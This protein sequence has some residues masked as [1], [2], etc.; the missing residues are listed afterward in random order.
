MNI[1]DFETSEGYID[2]LDKLSQEELVFEYRKN[3]YLFGQAKFLFNITK[4]TA[5]T[6]FLNT[7]HDWDG[8][9]NDLYDGLSK[10]IEACEKLL[11]KVNYFKKESFLEHDY[12]KKQIETI[13]LPK[14]VNFNIKEETRKMF[15]LI[16]L[17]LDSAY[18]ILVEVKRYVQYLSKK[19]F[20]RIIYS[21]PDYLRK[22]YDSEFEIEKNLI[23]FEK[24]VHIKGHHDVDT[25]YKI[26]ELTIEALTFQLFKR[27]HLLNAK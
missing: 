17:Y 20:K 6:N 22:Q 10:S 14:T 19:W 23:R 8:C 3:R 27:E 1:F 15:P 7:I 21:Q 24:E 2:E 5:Y 12:I 18:H 26:L 9:L 13:K 25:M 4:S 11:F 16:T